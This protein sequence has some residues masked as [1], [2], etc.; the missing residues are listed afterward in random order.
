M[1][2]W[3]VYRAKYHTST[4]QLADIANRTKPGIL[5]VQHVSGRGP[6]GRIPDEQLLQE[7]QKTYHGKVVIG[8]DLEVY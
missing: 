7:I 2:E 5:I 1:P 3:P 8:H 4:E 6:K